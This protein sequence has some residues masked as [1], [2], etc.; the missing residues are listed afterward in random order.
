MTTTRRSSTA[1]KAGL[2]GVVGPLKPDGEE[3]EKEEEW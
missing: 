1:T 2:F 3:K